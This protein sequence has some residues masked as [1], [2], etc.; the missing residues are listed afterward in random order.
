MNYDLEQ[1]AIQATDWL[2]KEEGRLCRYGT[3]DGPF[4]DLIR[5][6]VSSGYCETCKMNT[7]RLA[8]PK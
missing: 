8:G 6:E 7:I 5:G 2:F 3:T 1:L 4:C